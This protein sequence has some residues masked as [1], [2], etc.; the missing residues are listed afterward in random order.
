MAKLKTNKDVYTHVLDSFA[1]LYHLHMLHS[2]KSDN[3]LKYVEVFAACFTNKK[4][5]F[6]PSHKEVGSMTEEKELY[7]PFTQTEC[8]PTELF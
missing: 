2:I 5:L 8:T 4:L 6:P 7:Q 1:M 3:T